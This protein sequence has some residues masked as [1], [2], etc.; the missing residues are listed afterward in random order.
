MESSYEVSCLP[1]K[2]EIEGLHVDGDAK[3][4]NHVKITEESSISLKDLIIN[5]KI[6]ALNDVDLMAPRAELEKSL[7]KMSPAEA[8]SMQQALRQSQDSSNG[9]LIKLKEH[10]LNFANG[11]AA[12]VVASY[13]IK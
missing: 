11:V 8:R 7:H 1:I 5:G 4:L 2:I 9:F 13:L 3:L 10:L 12:S 6:E